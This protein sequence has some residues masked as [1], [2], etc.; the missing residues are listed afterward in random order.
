MPIQKQLSI[1][2]NFN[3]SKGSVS[4]NFSLSEDIK[5]VKDFKSLLHEAIKDVKSLLNLL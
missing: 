2:K 5:E 1:Q 4:L 3:Y